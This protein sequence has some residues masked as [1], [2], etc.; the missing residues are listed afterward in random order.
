MPNVEEIISFLES[1]G[2]KCKWFVG[3]PTYDCMPI[4]MPGESFAN[5]PNEC[6]ECQESLRNN[7]GTFKCC[8]ILPEIIPQLQALYQNPDNIPILIAHASYESEPDIIKSIYDGEIYKLQRQALG[9]DPK[10]IILQPSTD[11]LVYQY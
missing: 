6:S 8:A 5:C 2:A 9:N 1:Q 3:C 4:K 10:N 7:D 11:G